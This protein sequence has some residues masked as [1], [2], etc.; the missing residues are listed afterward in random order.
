MYGLMPGTLDRWRREGLPEWVR[1]KDI[2]NYFGFDPKYVS[3]PFPVGFN[4]PFQVKV[5]K[6]TD[7]FIIKT[8]KMGRVTKMMKGVTTLP[9][10]ID[11][12]IKKPSDWRRLKER[13]KFSR[14]RLREDEWTRLSEEA[15]RKGLPVEVGCLGFFW[16]PRDLM[17]EFTLFRAYLKWPDL[18]HDI[19]RT[20]CNL[21]LEVSEHLLDN[22]RVDIFSF[23][24]D[25][26]YKHGPMISPRLFREFMLPYYREVLGLFRSRGTK[27]FLVDTDGNI[28]KILPLLIEAGVNV[29]EPLEVQAGNDIVEL[30]RRFGD[31]IAFIGGID[32]VALTRDINDIEQELAR[33]LTLMKETGGYIAGLDHRV[34]SETPLRNFEYY[35]KR[36]KEILE[37]P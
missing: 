32:K 28:T 18:I 25:M 19:L 23:G 27:L 16:F 20:Y 17:G 10:A 30:R 2:P 13:L 7:R 8:D 36:V 22:V 3:L 35:V 9:Q 33:K 6:E 5:L 12:P 21:I 29:I 4:P 34:L 37:I 26:C 14:E 15:D 1:E 11:H 24:E 31:K